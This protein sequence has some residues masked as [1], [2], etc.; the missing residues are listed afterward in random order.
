MVEV[1]SFS[2]LQSQNA[3]LPMDYHGE[4]SQVNSSVA[5]RRNKDVNVTN[6]S[7]F[8]QVGSL[9]MGPGM[10]AQSDLNQSQ[11]DLEQQIREQERRLQEEKKILEMKYAEDLQKLRHG[12]FSNR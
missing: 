1:P 5:S 12:R 9:M 6:R 8:E 10:M 4:P 11:V 7:Q 2:N 3:D